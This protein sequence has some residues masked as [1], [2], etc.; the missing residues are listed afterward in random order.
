MKK[1]FLL[2]IFAVMFVAKS[3]AA[4]YDHIHLTAPDALKAVNWY[5]KHFGGEAGRFDR[6]GDGIPINQYHHSACI[7]EDSAVAGVVDALF[8]VLVAAIK[9]RY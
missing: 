4:P 5:V 9:R 7:I 8:P 1:Y 2:L 6:A 3:F